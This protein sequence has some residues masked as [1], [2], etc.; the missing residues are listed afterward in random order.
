MFWNLIFFF[1]IYVLILTKPLKTM[2]YE[3]GNY[4]DEEVTFTYEDQDYVWVGDFTIE[5]YGEDES[6]F[7]PAYGEVEVKIDNTYSLYSYE[8]DA[9]IIPTP[10]LLMAVELQIERNL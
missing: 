9:E 2:I 10:S 4:Y 6:E 7:A 1:D 8:D 5:F 3:S